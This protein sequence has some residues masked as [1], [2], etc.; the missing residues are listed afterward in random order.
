MPSVQR[1]RPGDVSG[2]AGI[3]LLQPLALVDTP[4]P[5]AVAAL[6]PQGRLTALDLASA[7][8]LRASATDAGQSATAPAKRRIAPR[9]TTC[10]CGPVQPQ[11][12]PEPED[13]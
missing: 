12:D 7:D 8:A 13:Q 10:R 3:H 11:P 1:R 6:D 5:S 9:I 4:R 2:V